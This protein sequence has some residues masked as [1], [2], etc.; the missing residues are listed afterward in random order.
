VTSAHARPLD[1]REVAADVHLAS[2]SRIPLLVGVAL[3]AFVVRLMPLLLGGGLESYGR[4][5]DGVYYA[6]SD[7]LTFGRVP[8]RDFVLLHPPGILLVL[9]PFALLGRL[10]SD[11]IGMAV[12]RLA[13]M[14]IGALNTVLVTALAW[15]WGRRAAIAA[16]VLYACWFPAVYG[17]QSTLLE[18]LGGTALLVA[19]LLL[20]KT[21]RPPSRRAELIAGVALGLAV[22]LKIWYVA[23]W[24]VVVLWQLT[25]RRWRAGMRLALSGF[26]AL[27]VVVLPFM[28]LA[29]GRMFDM[30]VRDQLLRPQAATSTRL[31]RISSILGVQTLLEGHHDTRVTVTVIVVVALVVA[32]VACSIDQTS[33]PLV[34]VL[35]INALVLLA[36]PSYFE[37]YAALIAAP[38]AVV[39]GVA[40]GK[41]GTARN[42]RLAP[43]A[44]FAVAMVA[45]LASGARVA[46]R[47]QDTSFPGAQLAKAAPAG[48]VTSDLPEALI[49]MNRLS[50]DL[51]SGCRIAI[52]VTGITY[53]S[54]HR[55]E[56]DGSTTPRE[57]NLAWQHYL[58]DYL[59]S[60]RSFV[61][62]RSAGDAM[63]PRTADALRKQPTLTQSNGYVLR[64]GNGA[65]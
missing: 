26:V 3:L 7:A 25:A 6:A 2:G 17:E 29:G 58:Y 36:S 28:V 27:L 35:A 19:L 23:P 64:A 30:V 22:A 18:P 63:A 10:T 57:D 51:R 21:A 43:R 16:G 39:L 37:H 49:Q 56:P 31:G 50:S 45:F 60:G 62:A 32:A 9:A 48:C 11:P 24:G 59:V 53:D 42:F 12:G 44:V 61:V 13:F 5:D 46:L 55:T 20:L 38:A 14:A 34:A 65:S 1:H 40:L 47:H 41:L 54:L 33:R 15:R 52:D 8:Y 4:Y